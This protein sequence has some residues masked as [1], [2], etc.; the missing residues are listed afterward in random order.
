MTIL[1]IASK[2]DF[3]FFYD[4]GNYRVRYDQIKRRFDDMRRKGFSEDLVWLL[5]EML[6]E[7]EDRRINLE[8][9]E[10]VLDNV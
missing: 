8:S 2:I 10:Q 5:C 6:E 1:S 3:E 9:I 4:F 7:T